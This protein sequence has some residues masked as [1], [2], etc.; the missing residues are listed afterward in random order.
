MEDF[1]YRAA[2]ARV[3]FGAGTVAHVGDEAARLGAERALVLSTPGRRAF[4]EQVAAHLGVRAA[5]VF[6]GATLAVTSQV[7]RAAS[8]EAKRIGADCL[9]AC[10]GGTAV[11]L[12]KVVALESGLPLVAVPTTYAGSEMTPA[13]AIVE[14]GRRRGGRDARVLPRTVLYDPELTLTLPARVS[15]A[16]GM[17]ALAHAIEGLYAEDGN[18]VT[19]LLAEEGLRRLARALPVVVRA[20]EDLA[21]RADALHGA[22]LCGLVV[23]STEIALHHRLCH[24]LSATFHL[25]HAETHA[26]LLPHTAAYNA[27]AARAA[28]DRAARALGV[29]DVAAGLHELAL[30]IGAPTALRAIGLEAQSADRA[31]DRAAFVAAAG[32]YANPRPLDREALRALLQRAFEGAPPVE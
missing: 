32:R 6:A 15:A 31:L 14:D 25:P 28:M 30:R 11:G 20:P 8:D 26:V 10:G 9:L 24:V 4:A 29:D 3:R 17:N 23:G 7:A 18:P 1:V 12:G 16:S 2:P 19:S 13:W 27:P 5:G 22:F 21:A